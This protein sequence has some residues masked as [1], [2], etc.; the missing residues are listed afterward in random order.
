MIYAA[1]VDVS[2]GSPGGD[3]FA[4]AV[5]S[6]Q[7]EIIVVNLVKAR[8]GRGP[9]LDLEA[10]VAEVATD[11]RRYSLTTILGDY[12]G[13]DWPTQHFARHGIAYQ[14]STRPKADVY[15]A[16]LP[17]LTSRRVQ[18]PPDREALR[19]LKLLRRKV[20]VQ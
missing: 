13:G 12:Y 7:G 16:F 18:L 9:R 14:R 17:L 20:G 19:Q 2:G 10:T 3:E 1:G 8:G 6:L 15:L 11:L 5:A 4:W